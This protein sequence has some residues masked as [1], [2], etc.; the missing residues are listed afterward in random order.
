MQFPYKFDQGYR[1]WYP[2][3]PVM[4][5]DHDGKPVETDAY[6]DSGAAFNV[7]RPEEAAALGLDLSKGR[8][9]SVTAGDGRIMRC[10]MFALVIQV[11]RYRFNSEVGFSKD[12]RV[13][14]NI[15]GLAGFFDH[16]REVSFQH[17]GR[18]VVLRP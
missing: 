9:A 17:R 7:F 14:L 5:F 3:I 6:V 10:S 18:Q 8:P 4:V 16:F 15:L 13:G 1:R 2:I 12:L 11:G